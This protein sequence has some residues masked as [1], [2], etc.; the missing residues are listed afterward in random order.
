MAL[1][2][3][4]TAKLIELNP[5]D[6]ATGAAL[7]DWKGDGDLLSGTMAE[8]M[9]APGTVGHANAE[10]SAETEDPQS[11]ST[12][13][14]E[15]IVQITPATSCDTGDIFLCTFSLLHAALLAIRIKKK[16]HPKTLIIIVVNVIR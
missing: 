7:F 14:V 5:F 9:I 4:G 3:D 6:H 1:F 15:E 13:T 8:S 12:A 2:R 10:G 11:N 16:N